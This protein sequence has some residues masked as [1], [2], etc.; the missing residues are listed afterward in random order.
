[1]ESCYRSAVWLKL[2][3]ETGGGGKW[4]NR[5]I[6]AKRFVPKGLKDAAWGFNLVLTPGVSP[7]KGPPCRGGRDKSL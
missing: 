6:G 5:R 1:M 7:K 2:S 3:S 4:A